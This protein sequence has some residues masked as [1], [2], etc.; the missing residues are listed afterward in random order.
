MRSLQKNAVLVAIIGIDGA[1]KT[2]QAG[3]LGKRLAAEGWPVAVH[4]SEPLGP[5]RTVY[6][7]AA[8]ELGFRDRVAMLTPDI[9]VLLAAT[10]KLN[11][12]MKAAEALR[13]E[14]SVVVMDRYAY[15]LLASGRC[16]KVANIALLEKILAVLPEPDMT[17][18]IDIE[19]EK[20]A[21]RIQARGTDESETE[22]LSGFRSSYL[23]LMAVHGFQ[24]IDGSGSIADTADAIYAAV[25]GLISRADVATR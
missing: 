25:A 7:A 1:G 8:E 20:A 11:S 17:I 6:D 2:T 16:Q 10:L 5:L 4:Y 9:D 22:F 23:D 3:I 18:F 15:C 21:R 13:R 19:P 24:R 12:M 14:D